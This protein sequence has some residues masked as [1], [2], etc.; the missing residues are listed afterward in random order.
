MCRLKNN[1]SPQKISGPNPWEPVDITLYTKR[2]VAD[3]IK[4]RILRWGIVL[5]YPRG[6]ECYHVY[7]YKVEAEGDLTR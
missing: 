3:M 5:D 4:L 1:P 7:P 2:D 6:S